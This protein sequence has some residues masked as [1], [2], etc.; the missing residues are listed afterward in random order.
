MKTLACMAAALIALED[1]QP[2]PMD[3]HDVLPVRLDHPVRVGG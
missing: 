1:S 3:R 2:I